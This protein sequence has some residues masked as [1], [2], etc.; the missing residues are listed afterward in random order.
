MKSM[1]SWPPL[2]AWLAVGIAGILGTEARYGLGLIFPESSTALPFT[3]LS[4]N[5]LGSFLLGTLSGYWSKRSVRWWIRAGLGP[6]LLG[7]FT[8]FSAVVYAV[9]QFARAGSSALWVW[10]L[11]LTMLLGCAA[12]WAGLF[13]GSRLP[14]GLAGHGHQAAE[15]P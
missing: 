14:T 9:D 12:A 6:G 13:L 5:V 7:S 11:I 1:S 4:I 8:T 15:K 10:Y 2:S 3:T